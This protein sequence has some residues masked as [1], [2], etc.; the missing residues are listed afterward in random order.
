[1]DWLRNAVK[2]FTDWAGAAAITNDDN[3]AWR[4]PEW[5]QNALDKSEIYYKAGDAGAAVRVLPP[6][7]AC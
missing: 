4:L 7:V 2:A 1:M 6:C 3:I 5:R